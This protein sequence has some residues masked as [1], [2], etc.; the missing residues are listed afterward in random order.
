MVTLNF[1]FKFRQINAMN[2]T[3]TIDTHLMPR[4]Y[5]YYIKNNL[6][7]YKIHNLNSETSTMKSSRVS[8]ANFEIPY[9]RKKRSTITIKL[10]LRNT[11]TCKLIVI[12]DL[13]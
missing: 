3:L 12:N 4:N 1:I 10:L 5:M 6:F 8:F 2:F 11:S 13:D 7:D 9:I